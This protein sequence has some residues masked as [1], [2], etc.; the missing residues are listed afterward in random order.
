MSGEA[1][2][3]RLEA[4]VTFCSAMVTAARF[5][6]F[7]G[8]SAPVADGPSPAVILLETHRA[9]S[10]WATDDLLIQNINKFNQTTNKQ[11]PPKNKIQRTPKVIEIIIKT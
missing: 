3:L 7:C 6:F 5:I 2:D 8:N 9:S 11:F 4:T 1:T 10:V